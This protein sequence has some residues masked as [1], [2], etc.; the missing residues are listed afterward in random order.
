MVRRQGSTGC[1]APESGPMMLRLSFVAHDPRRAWPSL[2]NAP[3]GRVA[4]FWT[5]TAFTFC[6][7]IRKL[8]T[9]AA[10]SLRRET[11]LIGA[12]GRTGPF[13]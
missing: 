7:W 8:R 9:A 1:Y 4:H 3:F 11:M 13:N 6:T 5:V 2:A 12:V 10:E